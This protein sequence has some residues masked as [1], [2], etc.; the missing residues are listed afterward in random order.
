VLRVTNIR[1][2]KIVSTSFSSKNKFKI[3]FESDNFVI[4]KSKMFV[5]NG[6]LY[7]TLKMN[8]MSIKD[9]NNNKIDFFICLNLADTHFWVPTQK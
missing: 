6:Y 7:W 3:V 5:K 4:T 1:K 9:E 2:N 8:V